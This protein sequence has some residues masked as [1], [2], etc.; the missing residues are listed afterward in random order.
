MN[1]AKNPAVAEDHG[2]PVNGARP[3]GADGEG[4]SSGG[5]ERLEILRWVYIFR[6]SLAGGLF[7]GAAFAWTAAS[8]GQTLTAS[9]ALVITLLHTPASYWVT[10]IRQ[11]PIGASFIY[12]QAVL[13]VVLVTL[14]VDLTG[15]SDSV[16]APL[17]ILLISAY[18]LMLPLRGGF[19]VTGLA[20]I[21]YI[22]DSVWV[23]GT[24]LNTVVA[25]Q[26]AIFVAVALVVGLISTKLRQT[27]AALTTVEYEL[28]RLRL[29]T[30]DILGNIPTAVLTIDG[31]GRLAYANPAAEAL[32]GLEARDWIEKPV[33]ETLAR[34]SRGLEQALER[35]RRFRMPVA[36]AEITIHRDGDAVPV[37]ISTAVLERRGG[38]PSVTAIMRDISDVKRMESLRQRTERLEAVAELS[39][40]LAHEIKNPLASIST[41]VQQ[42]GARDRADDDDQLLSRLILKESDRLSR[43]LSDFID[44]ARLR[45]ERSKTLDLRELAKHAV[46]V[47]RQHPDCGDEIEIELKLGSQPVLFEGDED[48]MHRV[49][50]NLILNAVQAAPPGHPTRVSVE[51]LGQEVGV[52]DRVDVEHPVVL[53]VTDDGPGI[54]ETDLK[55]IFDPFFTRRRGGSGLG[56]A[57]VHRAVREH[58]GAILV[59]SGP[60]IGTRF[61]VYLPGKPETPGEL[62]G[63]ERK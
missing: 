18:T 4:S 29:E 1:R 32:L 2:E 48:L 27:G 15:G 17:Y 57:I 6:I 54:P 53:R 46:E 7:A 63:E 9:L 50:S 37:G 21:A 20:C 45:I 38:P 25:L 52:P 59:A 22:A 42:L 61:T 60:E 5:I 33:L 43:L 14:V 31:L 16:V 26:L 23:Q 13:D 44:F 41:S 58:R 34:C 24:A 12:G 3:A 10:H 47:V 62:L 55:R 8:P 39:A 49:V 35:T 19:L 56:L 36:S 30:G 11:Q 51:V 40:S 28:Q